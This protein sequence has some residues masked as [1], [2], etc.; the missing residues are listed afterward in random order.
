MYTLATAAALPMVRGQESPKT[1]FKASNPYI[2][3]YTI[4]TPPEAASTVVE[5]PNNVANVVI[6]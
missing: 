4:A 2:A 5:V 1:R 3:P 6:A